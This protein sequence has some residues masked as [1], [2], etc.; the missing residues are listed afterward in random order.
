MSDISVRLVKNPTEA[1]IQRMTAVLVDAFE[2]GASSSPAHT[3]R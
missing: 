3:Q 1:E 2:G